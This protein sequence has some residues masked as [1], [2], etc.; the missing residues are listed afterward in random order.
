MN[1]KNFISADK[2]SAISSYG[3]RFE[4]GETVG[5]ADKNAGQSIVS[6]FD[7]DEESNEVKVYTDKGWAHLDFITKF[8]YEKV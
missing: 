1:R 3:Q 5:H 7:I 4:V 6:S 2:K 8:E